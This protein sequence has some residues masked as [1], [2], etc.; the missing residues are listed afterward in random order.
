MKYQL[1]IFDLD[2][3]ILDTLEDLT[4]STNHVLSSNGYPTHSI[5]EV[6]SYVGNG[7]YMLIK[8]AVPNATDEKEIQRLFEQFVSYYKD[9]CAIKTK[10]Y[11]G[12]NDLLFAL[13]ENNVKRAVVS[14]KGDFAVKIL[15]DDYFP[16]L[17]EI[18]VGEKQGVRKK[19]YADSVNEV[20]RLLGC[21]K[22]ET[23][24]IGDSE[25]DIQTAKNAGLA[26]VSVS[27]GFRSKEFLKENDASLIVEDVKG[28][29]KEL[30][31]DE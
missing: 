1:A 28:L 4:D 30:L 23:V 20:L 26:C 22:E 12:I 16:D 31:G 18:S 27:Y 2:G 5:D 15:I 7:I 21:K 14:N 17:F 9:H 10:A 3:T 24:Y 13:K 6:R 8:R 25:V 19:P 29:Y 11:E